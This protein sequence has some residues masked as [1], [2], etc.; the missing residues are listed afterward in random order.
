MYWRPPGPPHPMRAWTACRAGSTRSRRAPP[1]TTA[2]MAARSASLALGPTILRSIGSDPQLLD[3]DR[4]GLELGRARLGIGGV[5][6]QQIGRHVVGEVQGHEREPRAQALVAAE[7]PL[8]GAPARP[9]ADHLA[10]AKAIAIGVFR[11]DVEALAA[12]ERRAIAGGLHAGV[13]L[14]EPAPCGQA[15]R[16][17]GV[18]AIDR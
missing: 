14:L 5:D 4:R 1:A 17:L 11:R 3:A 2:S 8:A 18:E 6:R 16:K 13:V 7:G 15:Q 12:A 10:L 9:H